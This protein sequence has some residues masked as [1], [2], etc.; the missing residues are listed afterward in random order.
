MALKVQVHNLF[1]PTLMEVHDFLTA[2]ETDQLLEDC[3]KHCDMK[4]AEVVDMDADKEGK[5]G[6]KLSHQRTNS[7]AFLSYSDSAIAREVL[8]KASVLLQIHWSQAE[9]MQVVHYGEG[10]EY[11]PHKDAFEPNSIRLEPQQT[12]AIPSS[13]NVRGNRVATVLLYLNDV[14]EGGGT[15]FPRYGK[16]INPQKG[17]AVIFTNTYIGTQVPDPSSEHGADPVIK[18]EKWAVNLWFRNREDTTLNYVEW[19]KERN[20]EL[21][22]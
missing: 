9:N 21:E 15:R 3:K 7:N 13:G 6:T 1:N 2:E 11:Q 16:I 12:G 17:K 5:Q 20:K 8:K 14:P 18:G 4:R 22:K 19:L 10:E